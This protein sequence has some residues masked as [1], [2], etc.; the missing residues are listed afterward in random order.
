MKQKENY[1]IGVV[2]AV[3]T[4]L[5]KDGPVD[6]K[7]LEKIVHRCLSGGVHGIFVLGTT[8]EGTSFT[9][10][11][12]EEIINTAR[13]SIKKDVPLYAGVMDS[14]S[15]RVKENIRCAESNGADILVVTPHYYLGQNSQEEIIRHVETC[16]KYARIP[17][18]A[19]NIPQ[20][21][22]INISLPTVKKLLEIDNVIGLKDSSGDWE[23]FQK[24]IFLKNDRDFKLLIGAEELFGVSLLMGAD[25]CVPGIANYYPELLVELYEESKRGNS[26]KVKELQRQI[27]ALRQIILDCGAWLSGL[28]YICFTLGLCE[29]YTSSPLRPLT[30]S[31]KSIIRSSLKTEGLLK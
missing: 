27:T 19:Y 15:G 20:C 16:A 18:M 9:L 1:G 10:S 17:I 23:Q 31:Q 13:R 28:K 11:Q 29:E 14:S 25:G 12:K 21:T 7:S 30:A 4:P 6:G 2:V 24:E 8:G 5:K 26:K 22:H 3:I